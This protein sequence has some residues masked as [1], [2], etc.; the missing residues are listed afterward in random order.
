MKIC[1]HVAYWSRAR[2]LHVLHKV[3]SS[4]GGVMNKIKLVLHSARRAGDATCLT[5][6]ITRFHFTVYNMRMTAY[7]YTSHIK[8]MHIYICTYRHI[9][10]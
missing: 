5:V 9:D 7:I 6:G 10:I 3:L 8:H 1:G 4:N 2:N